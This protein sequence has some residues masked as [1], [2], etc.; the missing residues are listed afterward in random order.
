MHS[1]IS[2]SSFLGFIVSLYL[3]FLYI[4]QCTFTLIAASLS[5]L[6][7]SMYIIFSHI[8]RLFLEME[9]FYTIHVIGGGCY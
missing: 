2:L 8:Y 7:S 9:L 4:H 5:L 3:Y 1:A 6:C